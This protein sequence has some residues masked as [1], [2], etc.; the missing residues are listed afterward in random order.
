MSRISKPDASGLAVARLDLVLQ[1]LAHKGRHRD[2]AFNG[3]G[4]ELEAQSPRQG[5]DGSLH[6]SMIS[7]VMTDGVESGP[8]VRLDCNPL[9]GR[10]AASWARPASAL[11]QGTAAA[12]DTVD[13]GEAARPSAS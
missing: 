2:T 10:R 8:L 9:L 4:L 11:N 5:K 7:P 1:G 12:E 6:A 3:H 13:A